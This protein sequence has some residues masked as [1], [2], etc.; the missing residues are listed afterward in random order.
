MIEHLQHLASG[1]GEGERIFV[2]HLLEHARLYWSLAV[3]LL[4]RLRGG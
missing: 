3:G 1:G 2:L 4:Q